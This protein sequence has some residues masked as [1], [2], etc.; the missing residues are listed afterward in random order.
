MERKIRCTK[1]RKLNDV[2]KFCIYCGEKLPVS[3]EEIRINRSETDPYCLNCGRPVKRGQTNCACGYEFR[4]VNCPKCN[5]KNEY[6]SRF[7]ISCGE[8]LWKSDIYPFKYKS[9]LFEKHFANEVLPRELSNISVFKRSVKPSQWLDENTYRY[10][11]NP[12]K[13]KPE[14]L[15]IDKNLCEICSRWEIVSPNHCISC[16]KIHQDKCDCIANLLADEK[17]IEF[18]KTEKNYYMEPVFDIAEMKWTS[19]H[20]RELYLRSLA[21]AIG[22]SQLEYRERLKWDFAANLDRRKKIRNVIKLNDNL[23]KRKASKGNSG[24]TAYEKDSGYVDDWDYYG[25]SC[26]EWLEM[27]YK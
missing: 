4:D 16:L 23:E 8:K 25:V 13:L 7:C 21:P 22:E 19:K 18:L 11:D 3:D 5:Q 20:K 10:S 14:I 2:Q 17:R 27:K 1:C 15:S 9:R 6:A 12:I 26:E 24:Q